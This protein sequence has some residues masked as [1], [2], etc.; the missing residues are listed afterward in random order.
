MSLLAHCPFLN[1][2]H[3][4][5]NTL[6]S[7]V[8]LAGSTLL[9]VAH[10]QTLSLDVPFKP[11]EAVASIPDT[12]NTWTEVYQLKGELA[13]VLRAMVEEGRTPLPLAV[14]GAGKLH[15]SVKGRAVELEEEGIELTR[16]GQA[17]DYKDNCSVVPTAGDLLKIRYGKE[18]GPS[19]EL[20]LQVVEHYAFGRL[21]ALNP[22]AS[23]LNLADTAQCEAVEE[24]RLVLKGSLRASG[25]NNTQVSTQPVL[26]QVIVQN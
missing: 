22:E 23:R 6:L 17:I 10:A 21:S 1:P 18:K 7:S 16:R 25:A 4:L 24:S 9:G 19:V 8:L 15:F 2:M 12:N 13:P 5:M 11:S 20:D 3:P 26:V 14:A